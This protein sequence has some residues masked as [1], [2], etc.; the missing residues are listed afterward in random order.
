[1]Q[2]LI[3]ITGP[4]PDMSNVPES[5]QREMMK[6]WFDYTEEMKKAGVMKHGEALN[7]TKTGTRISKKDGKRVVLDGPFTEA[8]EVIGGYYQIETKTR[9]EALAWAEKCP[10]VRYGTIELRE[11]TAFG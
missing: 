4:E 11:V 9:E 3:L 2:Y 7:A 1:M 5:A 8:K 6:E 10:G